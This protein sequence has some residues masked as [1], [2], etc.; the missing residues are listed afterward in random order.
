MSVTCGFFNSSSG[1][2]K[3]DAEQMSNM[4]DGLIRDGVFATIGTAL[5]VTA[6]S[7]LVVNVGIGK[8]W[9]NHTWTMNDAV[10]P[11]TAPESDALLDR[12]DAVVL[13]VNSTPSVR[14]NTIKFVSGTAASTPTNPTMTNEEKV[15][16]Y[17]LC[18][19]YRKSASTA[20]AQV[21]I[22]PM[23][24]SESTPFVTG[25][26]DVISLDELLGKWQ[27]E[28]DTWTEA[29]EAEFTAWFNEIKGQLDDD[30]AANLQN[31]ITALQS[32]VNAIETSIASDK[33]DKPLRFTDISVPAIRFTADTTYSDYPYAGAVIL[34]SAEID[35]TM[36]P[37][38]VF[39]L[40]DAVSGNFAPIAESY[41]NGQVRGVRI[42]AKT[43]PTAAVTI[44]TLTLWRAV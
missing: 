29:E 42:F 5:N 25:I 9:F 35:T 6:S 4:F 20:I 19:I 13:E 26:L 41:V 8:A 37:D 3:Y 43:K 18:Y 15:H 28:L 27:D 2:R 32:S 23:V 17:P 10:L 7:G 31:Q 22:T 21:D 16:Q 1:D 11:L 12:I 34:A 14:A 38:V 33:Y 40:S 30:A 36:I 24:G 39:G 44:K